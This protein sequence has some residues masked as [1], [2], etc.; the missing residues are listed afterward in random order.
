M[1]F[2]IKTT[3]MWK[4]VSKLSFRRFSSILKWKSVVRRCHKLCGKWFATGCCC[5]MLLRNNKSQWQT[6]FHGT[7]VLQ[8]LQLSFLLDHTLTV[9]SSTLFSFAN[10]IIENHLYWWLA[11][12]ISRSSTRTLDTRKN[13]SDT[14]QRITN[15]KKMVQESKKSYFR[16]QYNS[17]WVIDGSSMSNQLHQWV[18]DVIDE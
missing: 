12:Y 5:F 11:L 13:A 16:A 1:K 8:Y 15:E 18:I 6:I 4:D 2:K 7:K 3:K 10:C 14:D 17:R 9:A